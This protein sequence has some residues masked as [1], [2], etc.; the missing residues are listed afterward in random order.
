MIQYTYFGQ[1]FDHVLVSGY[2]D[3]IK[4]NRKVKYEPFLF[5]PGAGKWNTV[6]G[7][8]LEKVDFNSISHARRWIRDREESGEKTFGFPIF[9]YVYAWQEF[10]NDQFHSDSTEFNILNLDIE[11]D[12]E[13]GFGDNQ[14]ADREITSITLK[15]FG[16]PETYIYGYKDYETKDPELLQLIADGKIKVKYIRCGSEAELLRGIIAAF[17]LLKPDVITGWNVKLFDIPYIIKRIIQVLGEEYTRKLSPFGLIDYSEVTIYNNVNSVYEIKGICIVDYMDAFKK[18]SFKNHES[19]KLDYICS[20]TIGAR[21][22]DYSEYKTLARLY[23]ENPDKFYDYNVID[24]YRVEQLDDHMQFM[25]QII[26]LSHMAKVNLADVFGTVRI[27]DV[28]IHNYLMERGIAV[29]YVNF[30]KKMGSISG[31][32]VKV[33]QVGRHKMLMSF[34]L[35][36]LYPHLVMMYNISPETFMGYSS[37]LSAL[38]NEREKRTGRHFE[39]MP[40]AIMAGCLS[41]HLSE[42]IKRDEYTITG[43]GTKFSRKKLG[44]LPAIMKWLFNQRKEYKQQMLKWED[45]R[46]RLVTAGAPEAEI[47]VAKQK[48]AE[49]NNK[50]MAMKILLNG[51]YGALSNEHN[52]WYSDDLA[53]SITLSGQLSIRWIARH[54][55]AFMNKMLDTNDVDYIVAVDTDSNYVNVWPVV[56]L[57]LKKYPDAD[58]KQILEILE[59]FA[60]KLEACI[61][62][63]YN[64]LYDLMNVH[65]RCMH[66]KLEAIGSAVW[67][68]KKRYVMSVWSNEGVHYDPP[69]IKMQGIDAVR[70]STP[71][72]CRDKIKTTIPVIIEGDEQKLRK[73]IDDF[74][75]EWMQMSFEQV[76]SP[77]GVNDLEKYHDKNFIYVKGTP[78]HAR[79][80]L[81]YNHMV[82][83][84]GLEKELPLIRSG[85]K[86]RYSRM[87]LPNPLDE[88]VF[89]CPD[90][91]PEELGLTKYIDKHEQ[92]EKTFLKPLDSLIRAS[93]IVLTGNVNLEQFFEDE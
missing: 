4:F 85:D 57:Y 37:E 21:K 88:D 10:S 18:F 61:E 41:T 19:Y 68:A 54:I 76:A 29:P 17:K 32:Y 40:A 93:G 82:A 5:K 7:K 83:K 70:S 62:E 36:S 25:S 33:P 30:N 66:M 65:D 90:E 20:E 87:L 60:R 31:G 92:F 89:A 42:E 47:A 74:R 2:E 50:Q 38:I 22:L 23:R 39:D 1:H 11:T 58:N 27:W 12:S 79:A 91:M 28:L 26:M 9:P 15:L 64:Q 67:V 34:D 86:I 3:G 73:I 16:Q 13:D 80:A 56:E 14:K 52:R 71:H 63:G 51:G 6:E 53:E 24:V 78:I 84:K 35:T 49:F 81:L 75:E 48:I 8:S 43:K 72:A 69:K 59:K 44:F 77:R 55:N 46:S 45:E